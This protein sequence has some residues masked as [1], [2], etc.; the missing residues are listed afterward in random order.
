MPFIIFYKTILFFLFSYYI[1]TITEFMLLSLVALYFWSIHV[2]W[3]LLDE[4]ILSIPEL[5]FSIIGLAIPYIGMFHGVYQAFINPIF[6]LYAIPALIVLL[7]L[8][9][10]LTMASG[11]LNREIE[12][13]VGEED[14]SKKE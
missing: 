10:I 9:F 3:F 6:L 14:Y 7:G 2:V 4:T 11:Y 8:I 1:L 12:K 5:I 13:L